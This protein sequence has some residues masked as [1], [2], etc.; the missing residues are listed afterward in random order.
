MITLKQ[1]N[2][3]LDEAKALIEKGWLQGKN[4][5]KNADGTVPERNDLVVVEGASFCVWGA[6]SFVASGNVRD[7]DADASV[8]V[9]DAAVKAL[10]VALN[11]RKG[12]VKSEGIIAYN[13]CPTTTKDDI[14]SLYDAAKL[15]PL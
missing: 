2:A 15:E 12:V 13:E 4:W 7:A 5:A 1:R 14:L 11:K 3:K 9:V 10:E 8:A 6:L